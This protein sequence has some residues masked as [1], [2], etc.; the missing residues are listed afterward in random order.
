[1]HIGVDCDTPSIASFPALNRLC[2]NNITRPCWQSSTAWKR[3]CITSRARRS[4]IGPKKGPRRPWV[5]LTTRVDMPQKGRKNPTDAIIR[6]RP[7]RRTT[8]QPA[9]AARL[10]DMSQRGCQYTGILRRRL[11]RPWRRRGGIGWWM[12]AIYRVHLW[13]NVGEA[14]RQGRQWPLAARDPHTERSWARDVGK[15]TARLSYV[16]HKSTRCPPL[17][18]LSAQLPHGMI[19]SFALIK[20]TSKCMHGMNQTEAEYSRHGKRSQR[21]SLSQIGPVVLEV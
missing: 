10:Y 17:F 4:T 8:A 20:T 21:A 6:R 15:S 2:K 7:S 13:V 16:Y 3:W 12:Q 11:T 19:S 1:M 14:R 5:L 9:R 18:H